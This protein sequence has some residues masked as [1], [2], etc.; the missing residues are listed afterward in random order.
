M[1][2]QFEDSVAGTAVHLNPDSV[3]SLRLD[4]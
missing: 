4:L 3:V 2:T 1:I